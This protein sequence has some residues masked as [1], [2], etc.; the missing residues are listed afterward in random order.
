MDI[1]CVSLSLSL[2]YV[3][4]RLTSGGRGWGRK[5][6]FLCLSLCSILQASHRYQFLF[7]KWRL[8]E[9]LIL[10]CLLVCLPIFSL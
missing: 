3:Q 6:V 2:R 10:I 7:Y 9:G 1:V 5:C 8:C 4:V